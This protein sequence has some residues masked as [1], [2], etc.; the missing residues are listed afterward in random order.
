MPDVA[1]FRE[2]TAS[3]RVYEGAA[4]TFPDFLARIS[5]PATSIEE[6]LYIY[7]EN[8]RLLASLPFHSKA[9]PVGDNPIPSR[10]LEL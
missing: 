1:P 9:K 4:R 3:L 7:M 2:L 10:Y 6:A 5:L 8:E